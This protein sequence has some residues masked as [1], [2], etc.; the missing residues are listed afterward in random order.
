MRKAI[1]L[2]ELSTEVWRLA[3]SRKELI[4]W[5]NVRLPHY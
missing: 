4:D 5:C 3:A 2:P 1:K